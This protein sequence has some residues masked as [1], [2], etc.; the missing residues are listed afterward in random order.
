MGSMDDVSDE[1]LMMMFREG[2]AE[3][4]DLLFAKY[5][6]AVHRFITHLVRDAASADDLLQEVFL[7]V[8]RAAPTYRPTAKFRTWLFRIARNCCLNAIE[9]SRIRQ[10]IQAE[11]AREGRFPSDASPP[12]R[13]PS[14]DECAE[15]NETMHRLRNALGQLAERQREALVLYAMEGMA[16]REIALVMEIPVNTVKT[17]IHRARDALA[18]RL[19]DGLPDAYRPTGDPQ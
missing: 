13:E 2:S 4:F 3:G 18:E 14:P 9:G 10:G 19:A 16:Y 17:L 5:H 11:L 8:A 6:G 1:R 15:A 12:G 7:R